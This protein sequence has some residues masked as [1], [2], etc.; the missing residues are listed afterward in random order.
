MES[1]EALPAPVVEASDLEGL[2]RL[3]GPF[4][5]V[6]L[7][8]EAAVEQAAQRVQQRW[9]T[10]RADLQDRGVPEDV[11]AAVD[12]AARGAHLRGDCLV[13]IATA[14][15][16]VLAAHGPAPR[17][18]DRAWWQAVPRLNTV[19]GWRQATPPHVVVVADRTGADLFAFRDGEPD[20]TEQ[21]QGEHDV[22]RKV[23]AGG[24]SER[25]YQERAEDSW[26]HNADQ[27]AAAVGSLVE[28]VD[29]RLVVAFG[30]VRAVHLLEASMPKSVT[31][32]LRVIE[33]EP[34]REGSVA[35]VPPEVGDIVCDLVA[36]ET[37]RLLEKWR[38]E[39]G[40]ADRACEG[41]AATAEALA[42]AQ[43]EALLLTD[44]P[45]DETSLWIGPE[46]ELIAT[47]AASLR[48]L[49]VDDPVE[50]PAR[51]ALVR[52]AIGT[53]AGL[54][55]LDREAERLPRDGVGALLRWS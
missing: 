26:E 19:L 22:I 8:T 52:A 15:G 31:V 11:L 54:R 9:R 18:V 35:E 55:L 14:E 40:Q 29:A 42:R 20:R 6:E 36:D 34:H 1:A 44:E 21:V 32:P 25:R 41:V 30:D 23:S 45:D 53:G 10:L 2:V 4:L 3:P 5:T 43:V 24:W 39:L 7:L 48:A 50:A 16:L 17:G 46:P 12:P 49:G 33:R 37:D 51:D 27:V 47:D 13:A 38:E 28:K